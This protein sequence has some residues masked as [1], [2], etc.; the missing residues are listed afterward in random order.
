MVLAILRVSLHSCV[1]C[2][3][4]VLK[5]LLVLTQ[6]NRRGFVPG[7]T[8]T[9][10]TLEHACFHHPRADRFD[11]LFLQNTDRINSTLFN[12]PMS[13]LQICQQLRIRLVPRTTI[14]RLPRRAAAIR[15]DDI[16]EGVPPRSQ[17]GEEVVI[18]AT[19]VAIARG[20]R[21]GVQRRDRRRASAI[22]FELAKPLRD[23]AQ[24]ADE[25]RGQSVRRARRARRAEIG[26]GLTPGSRSLSSA[27]PTS[28]RGTGHGLHLHARSGR[29]RA[30]QRGPLGLSPPPSSIIILVEQHETTPH[31]NQAHSHVQQVDDSQ[32][33]QLHGP[34]PL[35]QLSELLHDGQGRT[36]GGVDDAPSLLSELGSSRKGG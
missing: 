26:D 25:V 28:V 3:P 2:R 15:I 21:L 5:K 8:A 30:P 19:S 18:Y 9:Q 16:G 7:C 12:A 17:S 10:G 1:F 22:I 6:S 14:Y 20:S 29:R 13:L 11:D 32:Q 24:C 23:A 31:A 27:G 4:R 35:G 34:D 36:T 33:Q